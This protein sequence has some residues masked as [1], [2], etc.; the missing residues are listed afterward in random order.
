MSENQEF[1]VTKEPLA[2]LPDTLETTPFG[3]EELKISG[4]IM[5]VI[6]EHIRTDLGTEEPVRPLLY[7]QGMNGDDKLPWSL[8]TLAEIE[9]RPIIAIKYDSLNGTSEVVPTALIDH[10]KND[11]PEVDNLQ[12]DELIKVI[13]KLKA[14]GEAGMIGNVGDFD[15]VDVVAE[16]RGAV[17]AV[18]AL[19]KRPDLFRT[20]YLAHPAGQD[21]LDYI[22][23]HFAAAHQ[24]LHHAA[25]KIMGKVPDDR[26]PEDRPQ[27]KHTF[28]FRH[29]IRNRV[30]Q[31]SVAKANLSSVLEDVAESHPDKN[32]IIAGD[33]SH[34]KAFTPKRLLAN[35]GEHVTF[36]STNWGRHSI[37]YNRNA[38]QDISNT[39]Q[40]VEAGKL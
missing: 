10:E 24:F 19:A 14:E 28:N 2:P 21:N 12:A 39:L 29:L 11:V 31:K 16:S 27:T 6:P 37:G 26:E 8:K 18:I 20:V 23:R 22:D 15:S 9:Q 36:V 3:S 38:V 34:D 4:E 17:R 33:E 35:K 32:I 5:Q 7:I 1:L 30:E 25:R 13:E 40:A